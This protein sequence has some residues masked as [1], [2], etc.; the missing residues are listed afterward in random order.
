MIDYFESLRARDLIIFD[1]SEDYTL[2]RY[3]SASFH[4]KNIE[5]S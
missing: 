5:I 3:D 2:G 1:V 4:K